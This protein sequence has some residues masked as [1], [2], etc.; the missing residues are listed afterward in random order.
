MLA[1]LELAVLFACWYRSWFWG[2]GTPRDGLEGLLTAN[3]FLG[4]VTNLDGTASQKVHAKESSHST[5]GIVE[6]S[7]GVFPQDIHSDLL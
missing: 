6:R 2:F 1:L 4:F 5:N 7:S 3:K